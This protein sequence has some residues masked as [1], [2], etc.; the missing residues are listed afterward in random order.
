MTVDQETNLTGNGDFRLLQVSNGFDGI[1]E[2]KRLEKG[3][4]GEDG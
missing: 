2:G 3:G 1:G 4:M